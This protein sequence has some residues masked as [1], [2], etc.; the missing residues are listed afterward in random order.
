MPEILFPQ[1]SYRI[2]GA[3]F[4]VYKAKGNG[5]QEPLYQECL[6]IEL[7]VQAIPYAAQLHVPMEYRGRR[8]RQSWKCDVV[9]YEKILLELKAVA[10]LTEEHR[11]QMQN[12]L[13]A[14]K[15]PL[16]ILINFGHYPK[17]EYERYAFTEKLSQMVR[18]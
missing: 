2:M 3:C 10:R 4:E 12:Y 14:T 15:L 17:L 6:E 5:Y 9:C 16:G 8:L 11:T 13:N 7:E 1:E 18:D